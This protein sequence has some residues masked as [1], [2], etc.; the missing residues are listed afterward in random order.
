MSLYKIYFCLNARARLI[1]AK[2]SNIK[3]VQVKEKE[4]VVNY[5]AHANA[6]QLV[7]RRMCSAHVSQALR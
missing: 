5:K 6:T 4:E 2:Q 7:R 3:Q 1:F